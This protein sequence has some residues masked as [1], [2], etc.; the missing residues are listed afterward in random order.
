M[1]VI[2]VAFCFFASA[3]R[4]G[5][6]SSK[7]VRL[8]LGVYDL[9]GGKQNIDR[10]KICFWFSVYRLSGRRRTFVFG[11][12]FVWLSPTIRFRPMARQA[13]TNH[14]Y[15]AYGVVRPKTCVCFRHV[16]C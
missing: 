11:L 7:S 10:P 13:E 15:S 4:V 3:C 6:V 5:H 12:W 1:S 8:S 9:R 14:P 2:P 16:G